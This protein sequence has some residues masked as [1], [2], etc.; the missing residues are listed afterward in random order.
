MLFRSNLTPKKAIRVLIQKGADSLEETSLLVLYGF[1]NHFFWNV[2]I[3][4][5][6]YDDGVHL[7]VYTVFT[8][9]I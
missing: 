3:E 6:A 4:G 5:F 7:Y 2:N 8:L 1:P 9:Q